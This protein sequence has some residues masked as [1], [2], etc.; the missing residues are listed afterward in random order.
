MHVMK[1]HI[2]LHLYVLHVVSIHLW[3]H[4]YQHS[5]FASV[6]AVVGSSGTLGAAAN[7]HIM[8]LDS[9]YER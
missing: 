9:F 6:S 7:N 8:Q 2:K 5:T 3:L 1:V 4:Y